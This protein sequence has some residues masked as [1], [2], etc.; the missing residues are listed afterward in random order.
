MYIT[1]DHTRKLVNAIENGKKDIR[2]DMDFGH[3]KIRNDDS[4]VH[5][6]NI[7]VNVLN[8]NNDK[9]TDN[10]HKNGNGI[11]NAHTVNDIA[12]ESISKY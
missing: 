6:K 5:N 2:S 7:N 10:L 8:G 3:I 9:F 4:N 1:G 11:L 12:K